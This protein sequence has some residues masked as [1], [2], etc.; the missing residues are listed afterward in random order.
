MI[1]QYSNRLGTKPAGLDPDAKAYANAVVAT[2][3]TVSAAQKNAISDFVKTGKADGWYSSIKRL[4][5]PIWGAASPNAIDIIGLTSGLFIGTLTHGA[6]FVQ[7]NGTTGFFDIG[8]TPNALGMSTSGGSAFALVYEQDSRTDTRYF[9]GQTDGSNRR[10]FLRQDGSTAISTTLYNAG[11][12]VT[13][14]SSARTG[15]FIGVVN[16]TSNR[17]LKRR[18]SSGIAY[19]TTRTETDA[20]IQSSARNVF[21]MA[22]N[23]NGTVASWCD[24]KMGLYGLGLGF[25]DSDGNKFTLALKTM[26]ETCTGLTIP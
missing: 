13:N 17:Y 26:W 24:A 19:T 3:A 16:T 20:N 7:G 12:S 23:N 1:Y 14:S 11:I 5:L 2:G 18:A 22:L 4:Y 10:V 21:A 8:S 15:V 9:L 25:S 6:G